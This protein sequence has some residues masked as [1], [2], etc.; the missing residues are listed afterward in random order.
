[1][2]YEYPEENS[3]VWILFRISFVG[4]V[5]CWEKSQVTVPRTRM[6]LLTIMEGSS[7]DSLI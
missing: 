7:L 2:L 6:L 5:F 4:L 1:M 3:Y